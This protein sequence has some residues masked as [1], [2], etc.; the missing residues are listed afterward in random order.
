M[1][2]EEYTYFDL[3]L[4]VRHRVDHSLKV[5]KLIML[6]ARFRGRGRWPPSIRGLATYR[7][8]RVYPYDI[9]GGV[10]AEACSDIVARLPGPAPPPLSANSVFVDGRDM[11]SRY[12]NFMLSSERVSYGI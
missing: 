6:P 3:L 9:V 7:M 4:R 2:F 5:N 8:K 12:P 11:G 1:S 10:V